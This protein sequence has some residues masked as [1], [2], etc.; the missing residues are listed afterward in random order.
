[1]LGEIGVE[2]V[3]GE[4][5]QVILH[6][7]A[8][9]QGFVHGEGERTAQQGLAHQQQRQVV[10]GIH[11]EVEQQRKLFEGGM[12]Q[13]LRFVADENGVLFFAL[14]EIHDGGRDLAHQVAAVVRRFEVEL[15]GQLAEQIQSG[16]GTPMEVQDLVEAGIES[17]G[18]GAGGGRLAGADFAGEQTGAVVIGQKLESCLGFRVGLRSE[19]LFAIGMVAERCLLETEVSFHDE[20]YSSSSF[21]R[22]SSS[23]KLMPVGS[24]SAAGDRFR[25]GKPALMTGSTRR[26]APCSFPWK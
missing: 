17:R 14:V 16:P 5:F 7:D 15:Q 22:L 21:L 18:E 4:S 11:V 10:R 26:A 23:T 1:L 20:R 6:G 25:G 24:G 8:L 2:F 9:A 13:Q 19:Q 3:A 12:A